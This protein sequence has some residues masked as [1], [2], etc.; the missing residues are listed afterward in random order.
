MR[1]CHKSMP[2]IQTNNKMAESL[3]SRMFKECN[4]A[5]RSQPMALKRNGSQPSV[6]DLAPLFQSP[7]PSRFG[8][9]AVTFE[10]GA[11]SNWHT[12]P[13]G[14]TLI[15][16]AGLGWTQWLGRTQG[17]NRS[18]RCRDLPAGQ[19]ALARCNR[20]DGSGV[21]RDPRIK[22]RQECRV[23]GEGHRR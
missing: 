7:A 21:Y 6:R 15:V 3:N 1:S 19:E 20:Q 18:R 14:Q 12:H 17:R 16:T 9:A 13:C 2:I 23:A 10:P 5:E 22:R 8:G 4:V 11:R